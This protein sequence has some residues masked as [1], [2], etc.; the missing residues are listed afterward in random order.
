V[1]EKLLG[2]FLFIKI[3]VRKTKGGYSN[4]NKFAENDEHLGQIINSID[5]KLFGL[6]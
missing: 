3:L 5:A 1:F 2:V 6:F 4:K